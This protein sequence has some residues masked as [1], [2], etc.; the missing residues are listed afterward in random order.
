MGGGE[1]SESTINLLNKNSLSRMCVS[2]ATA[3][4]FGCFVQ[5]NAYRYTKLI[6]ST[7]AIWVTL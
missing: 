5:Y 1:D 7:Q 6:K 4:R 2:V 3:K